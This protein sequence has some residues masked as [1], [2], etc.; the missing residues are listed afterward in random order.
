M[1]TGYFK[2]LFWPTLFVSELPPVKVDSEEMNKP[3]LA[4]LPSVQEM[5]FKVVLK[6]RASIMYLM[7]LPVLPVYSRQPLA[8]AEQTPPS[9]GIAI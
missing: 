8:P 2:T 3:S 1:T 6:F 5:L 4:P 9:L 7:L